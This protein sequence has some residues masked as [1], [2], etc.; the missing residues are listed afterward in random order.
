MSDPLRRTWYQLLACLAALAGLSWLRAARAGT[1]NVDVGPFA[2]NAC[3]WLQLLVALLLA[4]AGR[5]YWN[6]IRTAAGRLKRAWLLRAIGLQFVAGLA[7][8]LTSN[9]VFPN[10]AYGRLF[11]LG[12]NPHV[13]RPCDLPPGDELIP[14][15]GHWFEQPSVY[16][17]AITALEAG[18]G[19]LSPGWGWL[20]FKAECLGLSAL[21]TGL[22]WLWCR[23]NLHSDRQ[24][25][26]FLLLAFNPLFLWE[27]AGQAHND[28]VVMLAIFLSAASLLKERAWS[29]AGWLTLALLAKLSALPLLG[30][31]LIRE[32]RRSP[33]RGA[34]LLTLIVLLAGLAYAPFWE[35]GSG[36]CEALS[37]GADRLGHTANSGADVVARTAL[38]WS[39]EPAQHF[40]F[41]T[42]TTLGKVILLGLA[43]RLA[44]SVGTPQ[45]VVRGAAI[46]LMVQQALGLAWFQP[47][48]PLWLLPLAVLAKNSQL[49]RAIA[50]YSILM[51]WFY[52][53]DQPIGL[54]GRLAIHLLPLL[55][56]GRAALVP[57][58][59]GL[60][61]KP[62]DLMPT[63]RLRTAGPWVERAL[64]AAALL[65][66]LA[67]I[68]LFA[69]Y[70]AQ[71]WP[72]GADSAAWTTLAQDFAAGRFY[73]PVDDGGATSRM[74][75]FFILH[76]QLAKVLGDWIRSGALLTQLGALLWLGALYAN[77]RL[78]GLRTR[79]ALAMAGLGMASMTYQRLGLGIH[80]DFLASG[81][82]F[83]ALALVR[84]QPT[85]PSRLPAAALLTALAFFTKASTLWV[86]P[87]LVVILARRREPAFAFAM[88]TLALIGGGLVWIQGQSYGD[89]GDN[90]WTLL[91][92]PLLSPAAA[93]LKFCRCLLN[94]DPFCLALWAVAL[95]AGLLGTLENL[96]PQRYDMVLE[97]A[98]ATGERRLRLPLHSLAGLPPS[99]LYACFSLILLHTLGLCFW[100]QTWLPEF[101]D[102]VAAS[103][104]MLG[105][106]SRGRDGWRVAVGGLALLLL[107]GQLFTSLPGAPSPRSTVLEHGL[108]TPETL[109]GIQRKLP[110]QAVCLAQNPWPLLA[111]GQHHRLLEEEN[112]RLLMQ[113]C[114]PEGLEMERRL[115]QG[116][117][118]YILLDS[119]DA[120]ATPQAEPGFWNSLA[121][122]YRRLQP[123]Y[124]VVAV[125]RPLVLLKR[126]AT[127]TP[128]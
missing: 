101:V 116:V 85:S 110:P 8:P 43:L 51:A 111:R 72:E 94:S 11:S 3:P 109:A 32:L 2:W 122:E 26:D 39:G 27:V 15:I 104:L 84:Q 119:S 97:L 36:I 65:A 16:G 20:A 63:R 58:L 19:R 96:L 86:W 41:S 117:Y 23:R 68:R 61:L 124:T 93:G 10:L 9:D 113:E 127:C 128:P 103:L 82:A 54:A 62:A 71:A 57:W 31:F 53:P 45:E 37:S 13:Q 38:F 90:W 79:A 78:S 42:V 91:Q 66:A 55:W 115:R 99:D 126:R 14:L 24:L 50:G 40:W 123:Y 28:I 77:L 87:C 105:L 49:A 17:P 73:R 34:G 121:D 4:L 76:A 100:P 83:A 60:S 33:G 59:H 30:L 48:Y 46:F 88:L 6:A 74:P 56:L 81:A 118:P 108:V 102:L 25:P 106:M 107:A 98:P 70:W 22:V 12:L 21:L 89:F 120:P 69:W 67:C 1:L 75:A 80:A 35:N 114:R 95:P 112:L 47:W 125:Q 18:P 29:A 44:D 7:L 92:L 64:V 5:A 52:L